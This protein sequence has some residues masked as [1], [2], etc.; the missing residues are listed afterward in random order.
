VPEVAL[1]EATNEGRKRAL[2]QSWGQPVACSWMRC[3]K[4]GCPHLLS[5]PSP[6]PQQ[7]KQHKTTSEHKV[8]I[9][10]IVDTTQ[11]SHNFVA[12]FFLSINLGIPVG[13][14]LALPNPTALVPAAS[15]DARGSSSQ[16]GKDAALR[17]PS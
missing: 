7:P 14:R 5:T 3:L 11:N 12:R 1:P 10:R 4:S 9:E 17:V 8:P 2:P 13:V 16:D 15:A 6:L